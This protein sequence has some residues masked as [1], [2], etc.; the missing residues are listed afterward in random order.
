MGWLPGPAAS[1]SRQ[2]RCD[3][4][5]RA[6]RGLVPLC[7]L[8]ISLGVG[9]G[10]GG[11]RRGVHRCSF[12]IPACSSVGSSFNEVQRSRADAEEKREN[13]FPGETVAFKWQLAISRAHTR[14]DECRC[15]GG[16]DGYNDNDNGNEEVDKD[17]GTTTIIHV[18]KALP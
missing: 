12:L 10:G 5:V 3:D 6:A 16:I 13:R 17:E 9:G 1:S 18:T 15:W 14:V 11:G 4:G 2:R 8:T 7:E